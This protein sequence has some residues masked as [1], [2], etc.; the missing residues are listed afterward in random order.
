MIDKEKTNGEDALAELL[1]IAGPRPK[2][3][4]DVK[5]RVRAAVHAEWERE[6]AKRRRTRIVTI[7]STLAAAAVLGGVLLFRPV[8]TVTPLPQ[9]GTT[10]ETA[11]EPTSIDWGGA[12]LR[13]DHDTRIRLES[14]RVAVLTNGAVY[15]SSNRHSTGVEIRTRFGSVRDIGTQFEVR[16][17]DTS[18][19][20]RVREGRVDLRGTIADAGTELIATTATIEKKDITRSGPEWAWAERAAPPVVIEG[21]T[22]GEVVGHVA[23]EK[24]LEIDWRADPGAKAKRLHGR[25]PLSPDEALEAA[26]AAGGVTYAIAPG[27][28]IVQ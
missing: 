27:R 7:V 24:G 25:I 10:I 6:V 22:L 13:L 4:E 11:G 21:M 20:V 15:Y 23:R 12:S 5:A 2:V 9:T 16:V 17:D 19:R 28:L 3:A 26:T 14:D 8:P 18:L 1:R